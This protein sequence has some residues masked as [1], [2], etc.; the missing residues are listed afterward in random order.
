[1]AQIKVQNE[2]EENGQSIDSNVYFIK[3]AI[4]T[5]MSFNLLSYLVRFGRIAEVTIKGVQ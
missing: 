4:S 3:V 2:V 1:V 5:F